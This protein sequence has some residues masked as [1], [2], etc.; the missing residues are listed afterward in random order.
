MKFKEGERV[1]V[2]GGMWQHNRTGLY[3]YAV[4]TVGRVTY[5]DTESVHVEFNGCTAVCHPRQ[6]ARLKPKRKAREWHILRRSNGYA[7]AFT[8]P[9]PHDGIEGVLETLHVREVL[10]KKGGARG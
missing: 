1:A 5:V 7:L 3:Q 10:P 4:R 9:G 6:I 8:S 2:Y